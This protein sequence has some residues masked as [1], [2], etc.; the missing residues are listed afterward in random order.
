[1]G[2]GGKGRAAKEREGEGKHEINN[3][4]FFHYLVN[5]RMHPPKTTTFQD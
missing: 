2:E 1:M 3:P 4:L 5:G